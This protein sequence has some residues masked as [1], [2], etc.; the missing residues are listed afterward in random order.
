MCE[1][2][3]STTFYNHGLNPDAL[4]LLFLLKWPDLWLKRLVKTFRC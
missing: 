2:Y 1:P 4:S 3:F